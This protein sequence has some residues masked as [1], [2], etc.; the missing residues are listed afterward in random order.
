MIEYEGQQYVVDV[1]FGFLGPSLPIPMSGAESNDG[2]RTFRIAER[3]PGEY[4]MQILK[5]GDFFSLYRFELAR[6]GQADC[7]LGHFFSHRHP[8]ANFVNHLVVSLIGEK[9]IR[10]LVDLK[11]WIITQ[12]STRSQDVSDPEELGNIL[13]NKLGI[14]VTRDESRQLYEKLIA[15]Q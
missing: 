9:E 4:H 14:Q 8:E 11:Y 6:Y 12:S 13:V 15:C 3:C 1:G 7:E 2:W 5:D 10:S